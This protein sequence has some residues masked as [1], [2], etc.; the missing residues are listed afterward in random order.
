MLNF[1][2]PQL[3]A[4]LEREKTYGISNM[5]KG[6]I[7]FT[8]FSKA[9]IEAMKRGEHTSGHFMGVKMWGSIVYHSMLWYIS[10]EVSSI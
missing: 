3:A 10:H 4:C 8:Q 6:R 9:L 5:K 1:A 7:R 2:C